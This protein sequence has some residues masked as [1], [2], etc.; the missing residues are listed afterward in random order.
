[1]A[2]YVYALSVRVHVCRCLWLLMCEY[3]YVGMYV[4][5]QIRIHVFTD[6]C[7]IHDW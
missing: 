4:C 7:I 1:M 3:M 5:V 6:A 2:L